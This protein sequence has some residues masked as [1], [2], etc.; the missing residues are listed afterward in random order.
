VLR[1]TRMLNQNASW[2]NSYCDNDG[3]QWNEING[4]CGDN[5]GWTSSWLAPCCYNLTPSRPTD[6]TIGGVRVLYINN[7]EDTKFRE[8]AMHC[9]GMQA[10]LCSK[11]E[12]WVLRQA[13]AISSRM[14]ASDHSDNDSASYEKGIGGVSDDPNLSQNYGYACCASKRKDINCP[15]PYTD[16]KGVCMIKVN[17][18]GGDWNAAA[19]DCANAGGRVCSI[20]QSAILRN[21][22][23]ITHGANWT[24]SYSDNDGGNAGVGVGNAGDDHPNN[25]SY[26]WACCY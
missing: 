17:N 9:V 22:G 6:Q 8:A 16:V 13:G 18:N 2:T 15:A 1:S 20:A 5:H 4:G 10:D 3:G 11:A 14:W 12:Y 21:E 25:S 24:E 23:R 7:A 19:T 26:G